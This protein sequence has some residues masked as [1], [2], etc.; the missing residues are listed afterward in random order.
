MRFLACIL[1]F[2]GIGNLIIGAITKSQA[3]VEFQGQATGNLLMGLVFIIGGVFAWNKAG[4][5]KEEKDDFD[6]WKDN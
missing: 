1:F 3:P 4:K 5:K 2:L 6:K